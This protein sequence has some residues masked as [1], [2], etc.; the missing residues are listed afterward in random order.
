MRARRKHTD[1]MKKK[2]KKRTKKARSSAAQGSPLR[3]SFDAER[4]DKRNY[5]IKRGKH[6]VLRLTGDEVISLREDTFY[7]HGE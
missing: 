1:S 2:T 7:L 3:M 4:R 5:V 6:V